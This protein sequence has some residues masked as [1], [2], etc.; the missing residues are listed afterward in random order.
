MYSVNSPLENSPKAI[1]AE[2]KAIIRYLVEQ[3]INFKKMSMG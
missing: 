1:R 2:P 3:I